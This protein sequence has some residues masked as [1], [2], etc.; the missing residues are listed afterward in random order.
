MPFRSRNHLR[1]LGTAI[2]VLAIYLLVLLAPLHQAAGLQRD[3]AELG[4]SYQDSWSVCAA[5]A[6]DQDG[7]QSRLTKCAAAGIGKNEIIPV[8]PAALG[9]GILRVANA[10]SYAPIAD[11][12]SPAPYYPTAHARAPPVIF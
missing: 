5:L 8:V 11:V 10:V 7:D 2:A 4:Y 6:Q 3:L 1:E 12:A 9:F